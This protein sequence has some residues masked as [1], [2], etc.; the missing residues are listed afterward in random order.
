MKKY[1]NIIKICSLLLLIFPFLGFPIIFEYFYVIVLGAIIGMTTLAL[2]YKSGFFKK[3]NEETVLEEYVQEL[4]DRFKKQ[5]KEHSTEQ[6]EK[7]TRISDVSV[8]NNE[9]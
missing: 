2:Q 9:E 1:F 5:S 6:E 3:E 8:H 4:K 7:I